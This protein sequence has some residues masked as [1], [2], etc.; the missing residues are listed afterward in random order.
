MAQRRISADNGGYA[1][2]RPATVS[3]TSADLSRLRWTARMAVGA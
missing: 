2:T 3:C 1:F